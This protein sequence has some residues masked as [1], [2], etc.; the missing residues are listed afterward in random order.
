[1]NKKICIKCGTDGGLSKRSLEQI[2]PNTTVQCL[3]TVSFVKFET[4]TE[5]IE[6]IQKKL[7]V[8]GNFVD[9]AW[10]EHAVDA[11]MLKQQLA[12][13]E[14]Q[15][16][17][18]AAAAI[19]VA[20]QQYNATQNLVYLQN[21]PTHTYS[22]VGQVP[23]P[24]LV[25]GQ[26]P[27]Q[28][29]VLNATVVYQPTTVSPFVNH[30]GGLIPV[31]V[32]TVQPGTSGRGVMQP[33]SFNFGQ[34]QM[35]PL[36]QTGQVQPPT[37]VASGPGPFVTNGPGHLQQMGQMQPPTTSGPGPFVTNGPGYLPQTNG[38]V[39]SGTSQ[40]GQLQPATYGQQGGQQF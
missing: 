11:G 34:N 1:M 21:V 38:Q 31:T 16:A 4:V 5:T 32:T 30:T 22:L 19:Q 40:L 27:G 2:Y 39:L 10:A 14:A 35:V 29:N 15:R 23:Q 33:N 20:Q 13:E 7:I 12:K 17:Q 36:P 3:N 6:A 28:M 24:P 9:V 37:T 26:V 25:N 18:Q 8:G